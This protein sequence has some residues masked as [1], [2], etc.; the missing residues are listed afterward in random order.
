MSYKNVKYSW[1]AELIR[2]LRPDLCSIFPCDTER[3]RMRFLA[4]MVTSGRLEYRVL[5]ELPDFHQALEQVPRRDGLTY[6]HELVY[7]ARPDVRAIFP[8]PEKRNDF[9]QWFDRHGI[10]E[11]RLAPLLHRIEQRRPARHDKALP[12]GVNVIGYAFGQLGIGEDARMA[13]RALHSAKVPFTMLNFLP[14][15]DI[16]QN[17]RSMEDHVTLD[18]PY[19]INLFCM[20]ALENARYFVTNGSAQFENR[21]NIGYWPWELSAWPEE[22]NGITGI[23]DEVWVSTQHTHDALAPVS[24]VPVRVMPMAVDLGPINRRTRSDFKLPPQARLFCFSF[25]LNSSIHRKNPQACVNAFLQ[26]FPRGKD[27][28]NGADA[29]GLVIKAHRPARRHAGWSRL[30]ALSRTDDRIHVIED[31]LSRPELL[32]LYAVCDSFVSLHRAEGFG[33]GLAEALQLGLHLIATGYSG[34]MDFCQHPSVDL[35]RYKLV[36]VKRGQYPFGRGQV[37]A[38][39]DLSHAAELMRTLLARPARRS[40][41]ADWA[42]FSLKVVGARYRHALQTIARENS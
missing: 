6:L 38:E 23:V 24:S 17:D 33:R 27:G 39:P 22:W 26:A 28:V 16:P 15:A 32:G 14:G 13:A 35:V 8:F 40:D 4:W 25:D 37:W 9:L 1:I 20:S 3:G 21:Y 42:R 36:K 7:A 10:V 30:K 11:H 5:D 29:V 34:N 41:A 12:F 2:T 31:T 19:S 18:G